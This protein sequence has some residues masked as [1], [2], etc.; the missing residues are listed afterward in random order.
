MSKRRG[1]TLVELLVVIAIIAILIALLVPAV[2]KVREAAARTQTNNNLKQLSLATHSCND[3]YR[4]L[5]P[6]TGLFGQPGFAATVHYH[7][8]PFIEQDNLYKAIIASN[9]TFTNS[10]IPPF[11]SP[12][13]PSLVN[14]GAGVQNFA[15]NLRVFTDN[16]VLAVGAPAINTANNPSTNQPWYNG[17]AN[18]PRTFQ[19]GTSNTISFTTVYMIC[20]GT[21]SY[22]YSAAGTAGN[23]NPGSPFFGF[24]LANGQA[25]PTVAAGTVPT[26]QTQPTIPNCYN[27]YLPHSLQS[28][29]LSVALFDGSVRMI[30]PSISFGTWNAAM[31][32]NDGITLGSDWNQ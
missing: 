2:Q 27:Q 24:N 25:S 4:V 23:T 19:D 32:P 21:Y 14:N 9:G 1:F 30:N 10:I 3:T 20:G 22:Y 7:L 26:F 12:Q 8:L 5:P 16:G 18:I 11:I 13:D 6:A 17:T 31:Q 15:A 29:G 28:G